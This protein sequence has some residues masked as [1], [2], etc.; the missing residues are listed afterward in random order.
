MSEQIVKTGAED[1]TAESMRRLGNALLHPTTMRIKELTRQGR[2]DEVIAALN[3]LYGDA[4]EK[5][6]AHAEATTA[7]ATPETLAVQKCPFAGMQ[8]AGA[9]GSKNYATN[10]CAQSCFTPKSCPVVH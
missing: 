5:V 8:A 9:R 2:T 7:S 1:K 3:L 10:A 6:P 4:T